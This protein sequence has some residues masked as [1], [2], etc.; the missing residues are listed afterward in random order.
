MTHVTCRLTAK[1]RDRLRNP[2]LGN[3][4][5][6]TFL[7]DFYC[8]HP[9]LYT[10]LPQPILISQLRVDM[11]SASS[12]VNCYDVFVSIAPLFTV[13]LQQ[14][15][16]VNR[17]CTLYIGSVITN[18]LP[19]CFYIVLSMLPAYSR[20]FLKIERGC[21]SHPINPQQS[22]VTELERCTVRASSDNASTVVSVVNKLDHRLVLLTPRL[23]CGGEI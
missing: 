4:V 22:D 6:A 2:T 12:T 15:Q 19:A 23:T 5:W 20:D 7:R 10:S 13:T 8:R 11:R 9:S 18:I 17:Q 1:N 16:P 21:L 3:R 14:Q